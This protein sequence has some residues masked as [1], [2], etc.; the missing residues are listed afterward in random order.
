MPDIADEPAQ[1][2]DVRDLAGWL[3]RCAD[4]RTAGVVD[5]VGPRGTFGALLAAAAEAAGSDARP[6]PADPAW[7][8][9]QAVDA[10]MGPRSLPLW[11]PFPEYA[12]FADRRGD[13]ARA[14]G[15]T[16]R[17][18]ADTLRD[19]LAWEEQRPADQPRR[20]GLTDAEEREL[21]AAWHTRTG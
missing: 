19:T 15:L 18:L 14:L 11:L 1:L 12:G 16:C 2:V 8:T 21:L 10:W 9:E 20:T 3:V 7:L 5:A 13:A 6:V 4:E 17:P